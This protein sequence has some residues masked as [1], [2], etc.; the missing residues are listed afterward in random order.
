MDKIPFTQ[1][2]EL[3][4]K[5]ADCAHVDENPPVGHNRAEATVPNEPFLRNAETTEVTKFLQREL[6]CPAMDE[7][8]GYLSFVG[9]KDGKHIEL[10]HMHSLKGRTVKVVEDPGLHLVWYYKDLYVKPLPHCLLNFGF[11]KMHLVSGPPSTP[12]QVSLYAAALGFVRTYALLIR[13]QS[14]FHIAKKENLLQQKVSYRAFQK[15]IHQFEEIQDSQ[16]SPRWQFGQL[17]LTR[18]N[19]VVR[20]AQP[21]S[22]RGKG[23]LQ[24]IYYLQVY[25][26][27]GQFLADLVAPILFIYASISLSVCHVAHSCYAFTTLGGCGGC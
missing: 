13:H 22:R 6:G 1:Q 7:M 9:R 19:W 8:H 4:S 27:T 18:L 25:W 11:W 15:F 16:V 12:E 20:L 5:P 23:F 17:R 14:D 24:R 2:A 3:I 10:L 21:P 26:Q